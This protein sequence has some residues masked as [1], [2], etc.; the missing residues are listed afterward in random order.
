MFPFAFSHK[1]GQCPKDLLL[2]GKW[3][4]LGRLPVGRAPPGLLFLGRM[5][6][7]C[8]HLP[9]SCVDDTQYMSGTRVFTQL[10]YLLAWHLEWQGSLPMFG[11]EQG[12]GPSSKHPRP[13]VDLLFL[14]QSTKG[15]NRTEPLSI[16]PPVLLPTAKRDIGKL[17]KL[18]LMRFPLALC[19][20]ECFYSSASDWALMSFS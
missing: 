1:K 19:L 12:R 5:E 9:T 7:V 18:K 16:P 6:R 10:G 14:H 20:W 4:A 17:Q 3:D 2:A 15:V 13:Q 8:D 11:W